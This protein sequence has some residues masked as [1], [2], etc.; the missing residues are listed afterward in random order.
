MV[1][2]CEAASDNPHPTSQDVFDGLP[3]HVASADSVVILLIVIFLADGQFVDVK[4]NL[5]L[6]KSDDNVPEAVPGWLA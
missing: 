2:V 1:F 6:A 4:Y 3:L 5:T